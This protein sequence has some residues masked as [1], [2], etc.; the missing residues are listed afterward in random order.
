VVRVASTAPSS[1]FAAT[2]TSASC[3]G[4]FLTMVLPAASE[5][6]MPQNRHWSAVFQ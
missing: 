1:S 5:T 6:P 2:D 3:S 4:V